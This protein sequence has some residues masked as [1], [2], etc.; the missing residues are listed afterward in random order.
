MS[1]FQRMAL[2][3]GAFFIISGTAM[4]RIVALLCGEFSTA[5]YPRAL[6]LSFTSAAGLVLNAV[7]AAVIL[8][9]LTLVSKRNNDLFGTKTEDERGVAISTEGTYGTSEWMDK[10]EA[11]QVYEVCPVEE[12]CIRDSLPAM[13]VNWRH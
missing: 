6:L 3:Y 10:E 2:G 8:L 13:Q 11:K 5:S 12:M 7:V 9:I 1:K 4:A